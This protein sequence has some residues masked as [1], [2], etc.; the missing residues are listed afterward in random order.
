MILPRQ[1]GYWWLIG[2][3]YQNNHNTRKCSWFCQGYWWL[4]DFVIFPGVFWTLPIISVALL[5]CFIPLLT[6]LAMSVSL[7]WNP[8]KRGPPWFDNEVRR[9]FK[10]KHSVHK[11]MKTYNTQFHCEELMTARR[12]FKQLCRLKPTSQNC[13]ANWKKTPK[14]FGRG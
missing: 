9:S 2:K 12:T 3:S 7:L 11:L 6:Q 14:D 10:L 8:Q 4:I 5:K 13:L 1:I